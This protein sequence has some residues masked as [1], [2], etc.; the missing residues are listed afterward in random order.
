MIVEALE[1]IERAV[2]EFRK[3]GPS[4]SVVD[5]GLGIGVPYLSTEKALD[6]HHSRKIF[7]GIGRSRFGRKSTYGLRQ[8]GP[9]WRPLVISSRG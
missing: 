5:L 7:S 3:E 9:W 2:A 8:G 4:F 1:A 6:F